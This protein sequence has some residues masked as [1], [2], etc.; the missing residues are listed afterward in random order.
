[1]SSF[2][3][4]AA[5]GAT[6]SVHDSRH[7]LPSEA[8]KFNFARIKVTYTQQKRQDGQGGGNITGGW[9]RTRNRVYS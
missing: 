6:D 4:N 2:S 7:D 8:I 9:D 1:M 3:Q 5:G